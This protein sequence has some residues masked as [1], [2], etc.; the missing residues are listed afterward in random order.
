MTLKR[1]RVVLFRG[2]VVGMAISAFGCGKDEGEVVHKQG[3]A[4]VRVKEQG[5]T[6][7][8]TVKGEEG[9]T[10]TYSSGAGV[11]LPSGFPKDVPTYPDM[12]LEFSGTQGNMYTINGRTADALAKVTEAMKAKAASEGWS[13]VMTMSQP[14]AEGKPGMMMSYTKADRVLNLVLAAEDDGTVISIMT[15]AQ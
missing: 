1:V 13:E 11:E 12:K 14:G 8:I 2:V 4:E 10:A 5:D 9:T 7:D 6:V 3:D 15:G